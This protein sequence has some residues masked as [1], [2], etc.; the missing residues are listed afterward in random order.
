MADGSRGPRTSRRGFLK[1]A[2]LGGAAATLARRPAPAGEA[3]ERPRP[4]AEPPGGAGLFSS[5]ERRALATLADLVLPGAGDWGA[6][7]YVE[8]LLTSIDSDPPRVYAGM[9]GSGEEWLPMDRVR[10][11][12]WRLRIHGSEA[13]RAPNEA[14]LG[15]VTGLRPAV[16]QGARE[17]AARLGGGASAERAWWGLPG[18]FRATFTEL[19]L[20]GSLG[21]PVYGGNLGGAAWRAFHFEGAM[22]GYGTYHPAP[23]LHPGDGAGEPGPDPLGPFTRAALWM[24]GFFSRRIA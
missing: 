13:V 17:A 23:H 4:D 12:A 24:L 20:E 5:E 6:A 15:P 19:V 8:R 7:D 10:R 22:L 2:A 1:A 16:L 21:D 14:L 18:E 9:I 3:L 11:H